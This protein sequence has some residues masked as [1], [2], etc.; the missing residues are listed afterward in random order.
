[1]K[2]SGLYFIPTPSAQPADSSTTASTLISSLETHFHTLTRSAPWT[3]TYRLFRDTPPRPDPNTDNPTSYAHTYQ[4]FLTHTSLSNRCYIH[5]APPASAAKG[6]GT[7]AAIPISQSDAQASLLRNQLAALW[8]PRQTL[9]VQ[10]GATYEGGL[11][12]VQIGEVRAMR[13]AHGGGMSSPGVVVCISTRLGE[14]DDVEASNVVKNGLG[15]EFDV[16]FAQAMI[17]ELWGKI[18]E[19]H[20][21]GRAEA[22]EVFMAPTVGPAYKD[23]AVRMWCEALRLR[24]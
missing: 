13:E 24:G 6:S 5:I 3:L 2:Y 4:H 17:R 12:A 23:A 10:N 20:D 9:S 15:E 22:R 8:S 21:L 11:F 1:M 18:R 19:G 7:V 16:D 14:E